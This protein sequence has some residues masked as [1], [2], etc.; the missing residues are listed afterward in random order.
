MAFAQAPA[1]TFNS[2]GRCIEKLTA[3]STDIAFWVLPAKL[4][5]QLNVLDLLPGKRFF[6]YSYSAHYCIETLVM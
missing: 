3:N 4:V 1:Y 6:Y 2:F 5:F